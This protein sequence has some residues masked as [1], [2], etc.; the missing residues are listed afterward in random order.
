MI[1][2]GT[3]PRGGGSSPAV[4]AGGAYFSN[5]TL[6][7]I[8]PRESGTTSEVSTPTMPSGHRIFKAYPGIEY[9]IKAVVLGGAYPYTYSLSNEPSGMTVNASTGVISWAN[10][11]GTTETPTLTVT[12]ALGTQVSEAWTITVGASGFVF[13][14]AIGGSDSDAGTLAAPWQT[15]NKVRNSGG[16]NIVYFRAGTYDN[17][18]ITRVTGNWERIEFNAAT[19]QP[20][21]WLGYPGETAIYNG[22]YVVST[23]QGALVRFQGNTT[24]P[25]YVDNMSF[26]NTYNILIQYISG[27]HY[28]HFRRLNLYDIHDGTDGNNPAGLMCTS[29]YGSATNYSAFTEMDCYDLV[30]AGGCK[31]YSQYKFLID[32]CAFRDS[33]YG[34]DLKAD[35][36]RFEM[37]GCTLTGNAGMYQGIFGNMNT[38]GAN[39]ATG[40]LRFNLVITTGASANNA[41]TLNQDSQAGEVYAYRNTFVGRVRM[42]NVDSSDGPFKLNNN[43][44]V[45]EDSGT[46]SGSHVYHDNVTDSSRIVLTDNLA[47]ASADSIVDANGLLQGSYRTTYLNQ[48]GHEIS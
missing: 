25:V 48:R 14:D 45:N 40:E 39:Q 33:G 46:P 32:D 41:L 34:P 2:V 1:I 22:G 37:R 21:Q 30:N 43:V 12:D 47:G 18:G 20:V 16:N 3:A 23:D 10:P 35:V 36:G 38:S 6:E 13:V 8:S 5:Y 27:F 17:T 31:W 7:L 9:N 4:G 42:W 44:I 28:P 26:R 24:Y 15:L 29:Q 19:P 11:T